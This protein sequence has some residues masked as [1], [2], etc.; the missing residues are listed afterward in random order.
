[1]KGYKG[2]TA[3]M[4]CRGMQY[5]IGKTYHEDNIALCK[6]G[7]HFCKNLRG[8]FGFYR[9]ESGS[10]FFEIEAVGNIITSVDKCVTDTL[11]I[12]RELTE[13]EVSRGFCGSD[14]GHGHGYER[15]YNY[16]CGDGYGYDNGS[17]NAYNYGCGSGSGYSYG[18]GNGY[19]NGYDYGK[20]IQ[21]VLI[22]KEV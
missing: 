14:D 19:G 9:L 21:N 3:D 17:G 22:F 12:V 15:S 13:I 6:R 11:T 8:V 7:L 4:T 2:M 16:G 10:R 1:M 5:E 18:Y 20:N